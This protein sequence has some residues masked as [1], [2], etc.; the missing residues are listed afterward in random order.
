MSEVIKKILVLALIVFGSVVVVTAL[1]RAENEKETN[2]ETITVKDKERIM[3]RDGLGSRYLVWSE[4]ETFEN[5]D[6]MLFGKFNS[7]DL[8][9]KLEI[10]KTYKCEVL[11]WRVQILSMYRNLID[12]EEVKNEN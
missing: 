2:Y 1:D 10:G 8:Q 3:D 11:G 4:D 7:S 12:C 9:G 5:V 6:S